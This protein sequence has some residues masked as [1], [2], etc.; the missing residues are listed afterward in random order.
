MSKSDD[1]KPRKARED[2]DEMD[3]APSRRAAL[4]KLGRF[5]TVAT[6]TVSLLLAAKAKPA[7]ARI[8]SGCAARTVP[9]PVQ[10]A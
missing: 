1:K 8:I 9:T 5:A 3:R 4:R 6:P 7:G 10:T 2:L